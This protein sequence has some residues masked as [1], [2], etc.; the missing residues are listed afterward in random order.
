M[1]A[2]VNI[3]ADIGSDYSLDIEVNEDDS[4]NTNLTDYAVTAKF[5]KNYGSTT[6]Y[7]ITP[8]VTNANNG[9]VS[10]AISAAT[11]ASIPSG[12]YVYDVK[13]ASANTGVTKRILEGNITLRPKVT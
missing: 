6:Q 13:I 12:K 2:K 1:A 4:S 5:A 11:S 9:L 3:Y 7:T 8:T 10:L